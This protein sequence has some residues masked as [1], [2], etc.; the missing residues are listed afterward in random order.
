MT[1]LAIHGGLAEVS[2]KLVPWPEGYLSLYGGEECDGVLQV[3]QKGVLSS[4]DG[5][6]RLKFE[7][8]FA[9]YIGVSFARLVS[10]GTAALHCALVACGVGPG[11]EVITTPHTY[12]ATASAIILAGAIPVFA[13]IDAETFNIDAHKI[14]DLISPNTKGVLP[15]HIYGLPSDMDRINRL[16][17]DHNLSVIEDACQAHGAVYKSRKAGS[18]GNC[19]GFS[20]NSTKNM[21]AGEG[22]IFVT[23]DYRLALL[24]ERARL[25][26]EVL[27]PHEPR[28]ADTFEFGNNYRS[29]EITA[30]LA[31]A[32]LGKV[33]K[34]NDL[35][36]A[37]A[38]FLT[39]RLQ[40]HSDLIAL[41]RCP[42]D[43]KHVFHMYKIRFR[44]N[45]LSKITIREMR[46]RF[47]A[48]LVAEGVPASVWC[49][50]PIY[51][52]PIF[53]VKGGQETFLPW[54]K[55]AAARGI[56]YGIGLCPIAEMVSHSSFNIPVY[57]HWNLEIMD[58]F[59]A[60]ME[61]VISCMDELM[62][63][64]VRPA[65]NERGLYTFES[66]GIPHNVAAS[67]TS[68]DS[69]PTEY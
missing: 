16:A 1:R 3:L 26:G 19:S 25:F 5:E 8:E 66:R 43:M 54:R 24:S 35:R 4:Q 42:P 50:E 31:S 59:V 40:K 48:A 49:S 39:D 36:I 68:R 2:S 37:N 44:W 56:E 65:E 23:N 61:K 12:I 9:D 28:S 52:Q 18:L 57:P 27:S 69:R 10:S 60:A 22:G 51:S 32:Q 34:L 20:L 17:N 11:D 64:E 7:R 6:Q 41:P 47:V 15:V 38:N 63:M 13:D 58:E 14:E 62:T 30:A 21:T 45:P 29:T 67:A 33:D 53:Q 55:Q 46:N